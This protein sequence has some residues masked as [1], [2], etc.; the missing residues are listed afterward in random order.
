MLI[1]QSVSEDDDLL[2]SP[3]TFNANNILKSPN[4]LATLSTLKN[5]NKQDSEGSNLMDRT[6]KEL[7]L[8]A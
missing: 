8:I 4:I 3:E 5:K 6:P 1:E 7:A 2:A